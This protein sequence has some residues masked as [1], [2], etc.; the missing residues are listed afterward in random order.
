MTLLCHT[1]R[2]CMPVTVRYCTVQ[3]CD[4]FNIKEILRMFATIRRQRKSHGRDYG[5]GH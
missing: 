1:G 3:R 5:A 4:I 2:R